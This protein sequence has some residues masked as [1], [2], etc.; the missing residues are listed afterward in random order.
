MDELTALD[1]LVRADGA[2]LGVIVFT[3]AR[4]GAW[5]QLSV[6]A[7]STAAV[8]GAPFLDLRDVLLS[9]STGRN[10]HVHPLDR[11]PNEVA[12]EI[13]AESILEWLEREGLIR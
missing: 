5:D 9:D 3:T 10:L 12:H 11:H 7:D 2:R 13:A 6:S 4:G 8:L 1:G